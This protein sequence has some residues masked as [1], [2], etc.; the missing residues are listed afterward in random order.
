MNDASRTNPAELAAKAE[1]AL[2][3]ALPLT[4]EQWAKVVRFLRSRW[5]AGKASGLSRSIEPEAL[6]AEFKK[7]F[8]SPS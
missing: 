1:A 3:E 6:L 2:T 8:I 5:D 7:R 4:D